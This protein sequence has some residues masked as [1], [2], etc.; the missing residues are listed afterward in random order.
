M[1][2]WNSFGSRTAWLRLVMKTFAVRDMSPPE[3]SMPN[4]SRIWRR[5][6]KTWS[7]SAFERFWLIRRKRRARKSFVLNLSLKSPRGWDFHPRLEWRP[8]ARSASFVVRGAPGRAGRS[9]RYSPFSPLYSNGLALTPGTR[10]GVFEL[11]DLLGR[12]GMGEVYRATD[13]KLKRQVAIKVLP[14][15][16]AADRGSARAVSTRSR[17]RSRR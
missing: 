12:G 9:R 4:T 13:T 14:P 11:A 10:L 8:M 17:S 7:I 15:S 2:N 3:A 16:L 6:R 1:A 5:A